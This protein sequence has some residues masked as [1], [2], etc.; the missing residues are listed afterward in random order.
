MEREDLKKE[1]RKAMKLLRSKAPLNA[2]QALTYALWGLARIR[3]QE[4]QIKN[5][6]ECLGLSS[7]EE[8]QYAAKL[9]VGLWRVTVK[10]IEPTDRVGRR[11]VAS[12]IEPWRLRAKQAY[13]DMLRERIEREKVELN[14]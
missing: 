8:E 14:V 9:I 10:S 6:R 2:T 13:A 12:L 4:L 11:E 5:R 1:A 7:A 3:N